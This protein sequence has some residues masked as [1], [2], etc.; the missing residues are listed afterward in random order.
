MTRAPNPNYQ[1]PM[2]KPE[3]RI[4]AQ[5]PNAE[6]TEAGSVLFRHSVIRHSD[7]IR[8]SGFGIPALH[9]SLE[10]GI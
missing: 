10:L 6:K 1:I 7:L 2:T 4:N 5:N 3:T 8:V 9:W